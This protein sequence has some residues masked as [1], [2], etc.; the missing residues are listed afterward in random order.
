MQD[1][2][3]AHLEPLNRKQRYHLLEKKK[4]YLRYT[5]GTDDEQAELP[6]G[7]VMLLAPPTPKSKS[8]RQRDTKWYLPPDGGPP[9]RP[10]PRSIPEQMN[11]T[12]H[13]FWASSLL[14]WLSVL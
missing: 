9:Q 7:W 11:R 13:G 5:R 6:K 3:L 1:A 12:E 14:A 4:V 2:S 10:K 8:R